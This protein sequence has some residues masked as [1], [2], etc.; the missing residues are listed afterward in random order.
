MAGRAWGA[1]PRAMPVDASSLFAA[2]N[3]ASGLVF[4]AIGAA[5]AMRPGARLAL[6]LFL[7]AFG[8]QVAFINLAASQARDVAAVLYVAGLAFLPLQAAFLLLHAAEAAEARR[9]RRWAAAA[10]IAALAALLVLL[11]GTVLA[12]VPEAGVLR[13]YAQA[14]GRMAMDPDD[15]GLLLYFGGPRLV[16]VSLALLLLAATV[17]PRPAGADPSAAPAPR[18][19]ALVLAGLAAAWAGT[20]AF[21]ATEEL[22]REGRS[23]WMLGALGAA[24]LAAC[25]CGVR[26]ARLR[27]LALGVAVLAAAGLAATAA[28]LKG[29]VPLAKVFLGPGALR[30]AGAVALLAT[31]HWPSLRGQWWTAV[32]MPFLAIAL[33]ASLASTVFIFASMA[34]GV[35]A[36]WLQ[37]GAGSGLAAVLL[38]VLTSI[39]PTYNALR[40][41][42]EA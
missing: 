22:L 41:G 13:V 23:G 27:H 33:F 9:L 31:L 8:A 40:G 29:N 18:T 17:R 11:V 34:S 21:P 19:E 5:A 12:A 6:P 26:L 37:L 1:P 25:A 20:T 15:G 30:L 16:G 7:L 36:H 10:R 28:A 14:D 42:S 32:S 4:V 3:I 35:P 24:A 2:V 39:A 38:I